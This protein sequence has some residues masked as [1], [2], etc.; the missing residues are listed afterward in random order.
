[1]TGTTKAM[2]QS[3]NE[4]RSK[5]EINGH[6]KIRQKKICD[7]KKHKPTANNLKQF[8]YRSNVRNNT[9]QTLVRGITNKE[10]KYNISTRK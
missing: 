9:P 7:N 1:M 3:K 10:G 6:K 5:V 8:Y 4:K 2:K